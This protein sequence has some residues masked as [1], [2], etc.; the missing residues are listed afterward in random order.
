MTLFAQWCDWSLP[1][2][3]ACSGDSAVISGYLGTCDAFDKAI[4]NFFIA[5]A[6]QNEKDHTVLQPAIRDGK[7]EAAV[8]GPK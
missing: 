2:S 5:Y 7:L 3:Y 8:A 1:L 4:A 6:N